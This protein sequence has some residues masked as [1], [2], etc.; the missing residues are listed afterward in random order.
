MPH[1]CKPCVG[2]K[3]KRGKKRKA[4]AW[5]KHVMAEYRRNKS[6]G[7]SAALVRAKKTYSKK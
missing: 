3:K 1:K 6:A 7:F 4:S 2:K 5:N